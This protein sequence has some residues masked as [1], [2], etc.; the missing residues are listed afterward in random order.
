MLFESYDKSK[1]EQSNEND[2]EEF[3][4]PFNKEEELG[5]SGIHGYSSDNPNIYNLKGREETLIDDISLWLHP[6]PPDLQV[7]NNPVLYEAPTNIALTLQ[8]EF[9]VKDEVFKRF[10][11]IRTK[12]FKY[13]VE[14]QNPN[15]VLLPHYCH[16]QQEIHF[17]L[18]YAYC[19]DV[20]SNALV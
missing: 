20:V 15:I 2:Q 7:C 13:L 18:E 9:H 11:D 3:V 12:N 4:F 17:E 6:T 1:E 16:L 14:S 19:Q 5:H 10:T 8:K